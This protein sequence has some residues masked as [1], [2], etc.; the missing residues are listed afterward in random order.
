M[1]IQRK[2]FMEIYIPFMKPDPNFK[3]KSMSVGN[4]PPWTHA[5]FGGNRF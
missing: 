1:K 3:L 2:G 5:A 4:M